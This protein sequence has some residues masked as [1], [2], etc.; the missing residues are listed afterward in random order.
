MSPKNRRNALASCP[1]QR[2]N[3]A[4]IVDV[5]LQNEHIREA[6]VSVVPLS[7]MPVD[8]MGAHAA[9]RERRQFAFE[10][11]RGD[12]W[13]VRQRPVNQLQLDPRYADFP[14]RASERLVLGRPM[15][16]AAV[17]DVL[18]GKVWAASDPARRAS[19]RQKDLADI[20]RLIERYPDLRGQ[21]P[22]A[23]LDRLL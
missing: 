15:R 9:D 5:P 12:V 2:R 20:A 7:L 8:G 17:Q 11:F 14:A 18:S 1:Q 22:S 23:I 16:V 10:S 3:Q 4:G 19:K 6:W 13:D 21:V